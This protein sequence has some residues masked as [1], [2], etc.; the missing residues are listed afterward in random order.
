M[1][2][3]LLIESGLLGLAV[4]PLDC[5]WPCC[6]TA[7][8]RPLPA[9]FPRVSD[10]VIDLRAV[11]FTGLTSVLAGLLFGLLPVWRVWRVRLVDALSE[12]SQA[13]VGLSIRTSVGRLRMG[14]IVGQ[15][16]AA[17]VLLVGALLLGRSF[18]AL[19]NAD[20]VMN[21]PIC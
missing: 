19:W 18:S 21:H 16:A 14:I 4:E 15:V 1:A 17:S 2:R 5:F 7:R 6:C 12:D 9:D 3:Q 10:V 20:R 13:P 11:L 8:F